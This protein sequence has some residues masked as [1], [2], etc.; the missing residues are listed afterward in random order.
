MAGPEPPLSR[1]GPGAIYFIIFILF[2]IYLTV[3]GLSS[4]MWD[5]RGLMQDLS[6]WCVD[7]LTGALGLSFPVVYE[8]LRFP[9]RD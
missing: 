6:L 9:S 3:L 8:I 2:I 7:S 5:L 1:I 4:S